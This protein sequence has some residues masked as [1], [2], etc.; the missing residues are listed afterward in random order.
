MFLKAG[1]QVSLDNGRKQLLRLLAQRGKVMLCCRNKQ[2]K[3]KKSMVLQSLCDP[4]VGL[5]TKQ[6][7]L[8]IIK[9]RGG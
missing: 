5:A 6:K 3:E 4:Q 8:P 1:L 2:R 7:A 9:S